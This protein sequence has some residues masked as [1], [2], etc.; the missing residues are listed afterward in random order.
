MV[1]DLAESF[2]FIKYKRQENTM[3][4]FADDVSPRWLTATAVLDVNTLA[5]ADKFGNIFVTR[6]PQAPASCSRDASERWGA[7][8]SP[9]GS[10]NSG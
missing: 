1:G 6:L 5:G 4:V 9:A 8:S 10:P 3:T 2:H 7:D